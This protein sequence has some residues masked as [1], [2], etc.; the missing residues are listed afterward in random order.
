MKYQFTRVSSNAKTGPIPTTMTE[1]ESCAITCPLRENGCYAENFPL[2]LHWGRVSE[3][4]ISATDLVSKLSKLPRGQLWRHNVAGDL[5]HVNGTVDIEQV[6]PILD[7]VK[8]RDLKTIVYSHHKGRNNME[9]FQGMKR[10]GV[11]VNVSC[12]SLDQAISADKM[13]LNAVCIVPQDSPKVKKILDGYTGQTVARVVVCPAQTSEKVTCASCG[14]C[15]KDRTNQ[16]VII[17]FL[18]HG[19]RAKKV[20]QLVEV[21]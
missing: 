4:G 17:G 18:P 8:S 3:S 11:N 1:K 9:V 5:P 20:N 10:Y 6:R 15:A 13:G 19:S 7:V 16:H 21:A 2:S 12:E 14:L